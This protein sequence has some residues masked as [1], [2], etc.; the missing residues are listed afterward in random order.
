MYIEWNPF[1]EGGQDNDV[2]SRTP[3]LL[4]NS[5]VAEISLVKHSESLLSPVPSRCQ[6]ITEV[7]K[8]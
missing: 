6:V 4:T 3:I 2:K 5:E 7:H 8:E 1:V